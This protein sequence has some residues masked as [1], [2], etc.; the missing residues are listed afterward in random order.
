M[1]IT[2]DKRKEPLG[3][4]TERRARKL[5]E[6]GKACVH[7]Y[8]PFTIII[9]N[10]DVRKM[11]IKDTYRI[12][13]DPGAKHTGMA[14]I[15][16]RDNAV[17]LFLQIEHRG[18]QVRSNIQT[19]AA[20]RR[21]RRNRETRYRKCK[22]PNHYLKKN[23]KYK[24]DSSRPDGW[25]PPSVKSV[26]DNVIN[27]VRKLTKYIDITEC[28]FEAVRFDTQLLDNPN[29]E[30]EEYQHGT[31]YGYELKEYLLET[32]GHQCQYCGGLS[33]DDK[34]EWEHKRPVS[35]GGSDKIANASLACRTCN[36]DKG[37]KT[38]KEY[39]EVLKTRN[40]K[41]K[42]EKVLN[43]ERIKRITDII[44]TGKVYKSNRYAAW[45]NSTR[46]YIEK[47]LFE[48]FENVECTS[49][50]KTKFN[51]TNLNLPKD[52]HFDALCVGA[53]PV[54]GYKN[55]HQKCLYIK[56]MGR[57]TRLLGKVDKYGFLHK[58]PKSPK[59]KFKENNNI[60]FQTGDIVFADVPNGK[61][62]GK[63]TGRASLRSSGYFNIQTKDGIMVAKSD[64]CIVR[65]YSDGYNYH[66]K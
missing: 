26:G 21:N 33:E 28:S 15:R 31:L 64:F 52:H 10:A 37:S 13:I 2:L 65:Q 43:N 5:L 58:Y 23:S 47:A 66:Y 51:R 60:G 45:V 19:R 63:F 41:T 8:Y 14:V 48:M 22:W 20:V 62:K 16:E 50:G 35:R 57:G 18:D 49:G 6:Q 7:R 27:W 3:F 53:V 44:N 40:P 36:Q 1:V 38:L 30:G 12:K 55:T 25:I 11:E 32:Y 29:I 59:R 46:R 4:T 54:D 24:F 61:Y 56:A 34:L 9:K 42:K 17:M 39:L